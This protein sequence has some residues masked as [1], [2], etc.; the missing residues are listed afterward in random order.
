M[1]LN[2]IDN[3]ND[4]PL[5]QYYTKNNI[6]EMCINKAFNVLKKIIDI[7]KYLF[8][9][10]SAGY[11][12]FYE[13]IRK[14]NNQII[15]FDIC[16]K[17]QKIR[18]LDFLNHKEIIKLLRILQKLKKKIIT[19]GNPPFGKKSKLAIAF[20][21]QASLFSDIICF[22][23]PNQ[24][25][26]Y[27]V[28]KQLNPNYHLIYEI[29]LPVNSFY[30][31][32]QPNYHVSCVFQIWTKLKTKHQNKRITKKPAITHKDFFMYQYNSTQE[33]LK[34]FDHDFDFAVFSQGYGDY[35][36]LITE[37]K[38]FNFKK[39]YILFK[40]KNSQVV[41]NLKS[42][43]FEKLSKGNTTVPGFRK[44]NVVA[45]YIKKYG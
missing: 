30:T 27:T 28:H 41:K 8:L 19:I 18:K 22:V 35:N 12:C 7:N 39:Q 10:P 2:T 24:F 20:L 34:V 26:K 4:N 37:K 23:L 17:H 44:N 25:K 21:N 13:G 43:N 5:G 33:A 11:G 1:Q 45:E 15:A 32:T 38:D 29:D 14:K 16:P 36:T 40:C 31:E 3:T 9:E 42:L 6:A